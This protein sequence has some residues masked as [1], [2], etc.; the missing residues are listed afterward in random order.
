MFNDIERRPESARQQNARG[1]LNINK[2]PY[3]SQHRSSGK[4][5]QMHDIGVISRSPVR[6]ERDSSSS[7]VEEENVSATEAPEIQA[8]EILSPEQQSDSNHEDLLEEE[9]HEDGVHEGELLPTEEEAGD[10]E[11][12]SVKLE[13]QVEDEDK[14]SVMVDT[15]ELKMPFQNTLEL[16]APMDTYEVPLPANRK[17]NPEKAQQRPYHDSKAAAAPMAHFNSSKTANFLMESGPY[18][19]GMSYG[20]GLTNLMMGQNDFDDNMLM[21]EDLDIDD[22]LEC[23]DIEQSAF[24]NSSKQLLS[25]LDN[26]ISCIDDRISSKRS[27]F[28]GGGGQHEGDYY[29]QGSNFLGYGGNSY[30]QQQR[31]HNHRQSH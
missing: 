31:S 11:M 23:E 7:K 16:A 10:E 27:V 5:Q 3:N 6:E 25:V 17:S 4:M 19:A 20:G 9:E 12:D 21:L 13:D 8:D 30:Q 29:M 2:Q 26:V 15:Q 18:L 24:I 28:Y 14:I 1:S 22:L